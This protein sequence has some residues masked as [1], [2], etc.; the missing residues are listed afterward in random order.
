MRRS[1]DFLKNYEIWVFNTFL[2][3][4]G[5]LYLYTEYHERY[6]WEIISMT[7]LIRGSDICAWHEILKVSKF[8]S[9]LERLG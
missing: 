3:T 1:S 8:A 2:Q 4:F 6:T 5:V 9:K 7:Y